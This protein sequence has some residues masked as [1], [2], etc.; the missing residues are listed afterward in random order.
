MNAIE[1]AAVPGATAKRNANG[2]TTAVVQNNNLELGAIIRIS[3]GD[4]DL[5]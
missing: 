4:G 1:I 3:S 2:K 5:L